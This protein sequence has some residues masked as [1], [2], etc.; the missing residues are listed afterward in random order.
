ML[1]AKYLLVEKKIIISD[2]RSVVRVGRDLEGYLIASPAMAGTPS[3]DQ[4]KNQQKEDDG[5]KP[6]L[7]YLTL[8]LG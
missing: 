5:A 6:G 8:V 2:N 1:S 4:K 7:R 3:P